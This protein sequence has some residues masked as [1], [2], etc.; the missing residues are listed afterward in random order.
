MKPFKVT[1]KDLENIDWVIIDSS[2]YW[3][4]RK[5][6]IKEE[7]KEYINNLKQL[8]DAFNEINNNKIY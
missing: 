2:N 3:N 5:L 4:V 1:Q 7:K 6:E 8:Y